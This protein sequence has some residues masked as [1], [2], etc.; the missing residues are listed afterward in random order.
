MILLIAAQRHRVPGVVSTPANPPRQNQ[1]EPRSFPTR[2]L[3]NPLSDKTNPA[4]QLPGNPKRERGPDKTNPSPLAT[5]APTAS[6][7]AGGKGDWLRSKRSEAQVPVPFSTGATASRPQKSRVPGVVSTPADPPRQNEPEP[8]SSQPQGVTEAATKRTAMIGG[9]S[10][11]PMKTVL[12]NGHFHPL[13]PRERVAEG[14][15]R[16][17]VR[18][19]FSEEPE[20]RV[21]GVVSTPADPPRQNEPE[22][23]VPGVVS[24]PADPPR[25]NEQS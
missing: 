1:P 2:S 20:P 12:V 9:P 6:G 3:L 5:G 8:P 18:S 17:P 13:S 22:P 10:P 11:D 19:T 15:V 21:P 14:R 25:Q 23:R 7:S 4:P 24:T 16:A